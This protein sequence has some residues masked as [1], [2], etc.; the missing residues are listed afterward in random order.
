MIKIMLV[1]LMM[2]SSNPLEDDAYV[3]TEPYFSSISECQAYANFNIE[4]IS[5]HLNIIFGG[6]KINNIYC[7]PEEQLQQFIEN[8]NI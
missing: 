6:R 3:F 8:T 5:K 1:A 2:S 7:V 4:I